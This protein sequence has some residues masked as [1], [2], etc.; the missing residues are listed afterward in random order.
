ML[1]AGWAVP[2]EFDAIRSEADL[3]AFV[4]R[5]RLK[6]LR[7]HAASVQTLGE[8]SGAIDGRAVFVRSR[9]VVAPHGPRGAWVQRVSLT[10]GT[11]AGGPLSERQLYF[12]VA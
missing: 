11:A 4:E 1:D 5:F 12:A 3:R 10:V 6:A 7:S 9:R 8:W 2:P